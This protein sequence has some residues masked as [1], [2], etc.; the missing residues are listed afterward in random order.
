[1]KKIKRSI[2]SWIY[3]QAI[4]VIAKRIVKDSNLLTPQYL[5]ERGWVEKDGYY[6]EPNMKDRDL[7]TIQFESHYYRV[8]HS[9][10]LTFIAL[11]S[12]VE[13]FELYYLLAHG[14]NGRYELAGI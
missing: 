3:R 5:L 13:W 1:M 2:K 7:I 12:S 4:K 8:W 6:T 9:S 10:K 11:E 14:D